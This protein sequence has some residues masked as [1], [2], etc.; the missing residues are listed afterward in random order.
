M[1]LLLAVLLI[2]TA[3]SGSEPNYVR[4]V[5]DSS[6]A[7]LQT[8]VSRFQN[9]QGVHVDLVG[10]VHIA[11]KP[12]FQDLNERFKHFDAVLYELVGGPMP[13]QGDL[14]DRPRDPKLAW[15]GELHSRMQKTLVLES[16]LEQINYHASNFVHADMTVE[17][18]EAAKE[19]KNESFLGLMF[20]AFVVQSELAEQGQASTG[21]GL[22]K[23]LEILYRQ[24]S[25]TELKRLI[26]R[27]FDSMETLMAGMES[28][29]GTVIVTERN[30]IALKVMNAQIAKG[31]KNLA[32]FYGAAHLPSMEK[33]LKEHGFKLIKTEW[34]KAWSLPPE[35]PVQS[36]PAKP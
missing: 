3:A 32:I 12:Y 35:T 33:T 4:F 7:S 23:L 15:I 19:K 25:S 9:A 28:G 2:S 17:E 10:A 8:A 31:R 29:E 11:D 14:K 20:K 13:A 22:V 6:G 34:L 5:E 26:G 36:A 1:R 16:Q 27:E 24:D 30:R 18:F 21:P